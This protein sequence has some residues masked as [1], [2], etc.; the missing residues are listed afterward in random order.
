MAHLLGWSPGDPGWP[1]GEGRQAV[2]G[3]NGELGKRLLSP[4]ESLAGLRSFRF[5]APSFDC[6][7]V[8]ECPRCL[9]VLSPRSDDAAGAATASSPML[10]LD[11]LL[12]G[13]W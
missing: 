7:T 6:P 13:C 9:P 3:M 1:R 12:L 11:C 8:V 4:G 10:G 2:Q 5:R